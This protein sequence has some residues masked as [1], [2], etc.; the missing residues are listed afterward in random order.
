MVK[1]LS[2]SAL[3]FLIV[4]SILMVLTIVKPCYALGSGKMRGDYPKCQQECLEQL[5]KDMAQA[6]GDF[7]KDKNRIFYEEKVEKVNQKY[8]QC[9]NSCKEPMPVK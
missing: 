7:V 9:L 6:S 3:V 2:T 5:D 8:N 1:P 4:G